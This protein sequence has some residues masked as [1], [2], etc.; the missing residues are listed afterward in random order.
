[1]HCSIFF[2]NPS[3]QLIQRYNVFCSV[4][5]IHISIKYLLRKRLYNKNT[6]I[7]LLIFKRLFDFISN[8]RVLFVLMPQQGPITTSLLRPT[9]ISNVHVLRF[10]RAGNFKMQWFA[11]LQFIKSFDILKRRGINCISLDIPLIVNLNFVNP[12]IL[13][14]ISSK[15]L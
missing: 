13:L 3:K 11:L 5:L 4:I 7:P 2:N 8:L 9:G 15:L 6:H 12:C 14:T 1:M 10:T